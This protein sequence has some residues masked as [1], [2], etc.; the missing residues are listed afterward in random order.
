[1]IQTDQL[2]PFFGAI[3]DMRPVADLP[4]QTLHSLLITEEESRLLRAGMPKLLGSQLYKPLE[5]AIAELF[6]N[7]QVGFR[8]AELHGKSANRMLP[9]HIARHNEPLLGRPAAQDA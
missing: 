8:V 5:A 9:V 4:P 1:M 7:G 2:L 6:R 3:S